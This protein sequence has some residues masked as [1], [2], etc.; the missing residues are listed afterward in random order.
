MTNELTRF[1]KGQW[2][3]AYTYFGAHF[4]PQGCVFRLWAPHA[5]Q[6]RL[7]GDFNGWQ[8]AAM[9]RV[10]GGV[11]EL[12]V[13]GVKPYDSYKYV[14]TGA[15]GKV[16]WKADPYA[17]H[18]ATRPDTNSKVFDIGGYTWGDG[19]WEER[20]GGADGPLHIYEVHLGSWRR[21]ADG[22]FL[23]YR[24]LAEELPA[25]VAACGYNAVELLPV[26]EYPLDDSWGYQCTGYFA[27]TSRY[28]TPH[29]FMY[30]VDRLHQ[31]GITVILDWVGAHFCKDAHGLM[32]LDGTCLYEYGDPL[33][34]EH[35]GWGTCVF[36]FG[37]GEVCSFLLS[38]AAYWLREY[39]I[40]GLRV[41]AVASMLY[42]DYGRTAWRPNRHGGRENLEAIAFLRSLNRLAH[43]ISPKTIMVAEESTAWPHVT[44]DWPDGLGFD[45]KWN[46]GWMNDVCHYLKMDPYF[47]RDHHGDVTFSMVYAFSE[48]FV[49]PISHDEV[50]HMK[51]SLRGKMPGGD[52]EQLAGVRG[53]YAYMLCH[54]G[55]KLTFMGTE[56]AQW[57]EWDFAGQLDWYLCE[58]ADCRGTQACIR[59]LNHFYL[60]TPPL[61]DNDRDWNGFTWLVADDKCNNVLVFVRRDRTGDERIIAVNFSP[62]KRENYRFGVDK[63]GVYEE[64]F[65]TDDA[66]WGGSGAGSGTVAA[67]AI[68]SHGRPQS[69]AV[70]IPPLGAVIWRRTEQSGETT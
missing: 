51:G 4:T 8:G 37:K 56:L 61:W 45:L 36:D 65:N 23:S 43:D 54:P 59:A 52:K 55:K 62:V 35:A 13:A 20:R 5:A 53:F 12:T 58:D 25:Y 11:W 33:K 1:A 60:N 19:A 68:P 26:T 42:L 38:S 31:A 47:R 29:D 39:H 69:M 70:T 27:P 64:V 10:D 17:F 44:G 9:Q 28:G 49:L 14:V 40:D 6:V 63:I 22:H 46:M 41:D 7:A 24:Q 3:R 2:A 66:Q 48:H 16:R 32:E 34:R 30:L 18:A 21:H 67:E 15:D 50:V 57:H